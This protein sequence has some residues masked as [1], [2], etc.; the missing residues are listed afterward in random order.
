MSS[1]IFKKLY[2]GSDKSM[3]AYKVVEVGSFCM[4]EFNEIGDQETTD[5]TRMS[6]P[7]PPPTCENVILDQG[8]EHCHAIG[9]R[10]AIHE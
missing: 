1:N 5:F 2:G 7:V 3:L 8:D 6:Q 4:D 9:T 10:Q